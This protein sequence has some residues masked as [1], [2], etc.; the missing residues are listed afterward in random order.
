MEATSSV[1]DEIAR[2]YLGGQPGVVEETHSVLPEF[3]SLSRPSEA[4]DHGEKLA[5]LL[6]QNSS[7][8]RRT[9]MV[10]AWHM[11]LTAQRQFHCE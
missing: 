2:S 10:R 11:H 7:M 8:M 1:L 5:T 3:Q 4:E 6:E 9:M